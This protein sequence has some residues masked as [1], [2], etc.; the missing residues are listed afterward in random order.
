MFVA[1]HQ[2]GPIEDE[3]SRLQPTLDALP[4]TPTLVHWTGVG[5]WLCWDDPDQFN[6]LHIPFLSGKE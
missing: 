1:R 4:T 6:A 5:P 3:V 2:G